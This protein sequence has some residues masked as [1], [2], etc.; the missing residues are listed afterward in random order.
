MDK[1]DTNV[2][3]LIKLD[4]NAEVLMENK[5]TFLKFRQSFHWT[6]SEIKKLIVTILLCSKFPQSL[7]MLSLRVALFS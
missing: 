5:A 7:S 1:N 6:A 4:Q 3:L 2:Y